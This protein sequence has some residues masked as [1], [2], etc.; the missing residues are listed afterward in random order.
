[1]WCSMHNL[2]F[3]CIHPQSELTTTFKFLHIPEWLST[4]PREMGSLCFTLLHTVSVGG[5]SESNHSSILHFLVKKK[6]EMDQCSCVSCTVQTTKKKKH[7]RGCCTLHSANNRSMRTQS[8]YALHKYSTTC[9]TSTHRW[10]LTLYFI[11]ALS[12]F[13]GCSVLILED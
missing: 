6:G 5:W 2:L 3:W 8:T 9:N 11:P 7:Q 12:R 10:V 13:W 4:R 1:M